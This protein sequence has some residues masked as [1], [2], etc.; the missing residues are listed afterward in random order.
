[1]Y[2]L[3]S[4]ISLIGF[5]RDFLVQQHPLQHHNFESNIMLGLTRQQKSVVFG[6]DGI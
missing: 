2:N 3:Y 4:H 1:M 6:K 5:Y